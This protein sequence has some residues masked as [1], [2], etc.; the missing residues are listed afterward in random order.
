MLVENSGEQLCE[1]RGAVLEQAVMSQEAFARVP[2]HFLDSITWICLIRIAMV[3][4][5]RPAAK[6]QSLFFVIHLTP[7]NRLVSVISK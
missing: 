7:V 3:Q 4:W 6:M 2:Q 5:T 1:S